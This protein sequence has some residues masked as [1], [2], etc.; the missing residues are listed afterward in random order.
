MCIINCLHE[1]QKVDNF[2]MDDIMNGVWTPA[3]VA[4]I[5]INHRENIELAIK[6]IYE[7]KVI[8]EKEEK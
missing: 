2:D 1:G 3:E 4:Q 6:N 5:C 8:P 7:R